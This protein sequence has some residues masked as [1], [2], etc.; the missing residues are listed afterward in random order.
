MK[1]LEIIRK[2]RSIRKFSDKQVE[3]EKLSLLKEAALRA[4]SSRGLNSWEF[5]F[6]SDKTMIAKFAKA[7]IH[8]AEFLVGAPLAVVVCGKPDES[9]V[10]IENCSIASIFIQLA[11]ID[12]GLG[13]CWVQIRN[14]LHSREMSS[15]DYLAGILGLPDETEILAIIGVGHP[16]ERPRPHPESSLEKE[17]VKDIL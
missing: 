9:D 16:A 11:A 2:R 13:S 15:R 3:P 10:W 14:R 6:V 4:P 12:L 7:R 1:F 17:K 5:I 8:G